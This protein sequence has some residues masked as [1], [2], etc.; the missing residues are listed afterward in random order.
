MESAVLQHEDAP[1]GATEAPGEAFSSDDASRDWIGDERV[2]MP[3]E[4]PV[5]SLD[6]LAGPIFSGPRRPIGSVRVKLSRC[7]TLVGDARFREKSASSIWH[8]K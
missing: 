1:G 5:G 3:D 7:S 6:E 4:S 8:T 2:S